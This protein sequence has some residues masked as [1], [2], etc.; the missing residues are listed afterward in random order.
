MTESQV[1]ILKSFKNLLKKKLRNL[2]RNFSGT[3]IPLIRL[4]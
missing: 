1:E 4:C 2:L 3:F